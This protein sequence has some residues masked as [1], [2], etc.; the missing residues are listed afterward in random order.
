MPKQDKRIEIRPGDI[1]ELD[2]CMM[3]NSIHSDKTGIFME[4]YDTVRTGLAFV[5]SR[6]GYTNAARTNEAILIL[7]N[8]KLRWA[9]MQDYDYK[10]KITVI[11]PAS[12]HCRSRV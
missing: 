6:P 3:W 5:V 11:V 1:V 9:W 4:D 10:D 7:V 8:N 2:A 12:A